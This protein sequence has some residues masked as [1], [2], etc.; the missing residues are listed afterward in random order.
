MIKCWN[1]ICKG[2]LMILS[3]TKDIAKLL[4]I[5]TKNMIS[6]S[7]QFTEPTPLLDDWVMGLEFADEG[8][9]AVYLI[10]AHSGLLL[11]E[12]AAKAEL[13][14]FLALFAQQLHDV[15]KGLKLNPAKYMKYF[16]RLFDQIILV[17]NDNRSISASIGQI[18]T[19]IEIME[20]KAY[21]VN[22]PLDTLEVINHYNNLIQR[23]HEW[24]SP[25]EV[26]RELLIK[27]HN[28]DVLI[29]PMEAA[30]ETFH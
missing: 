15:I 19:H 8:C 2:D 25:F 16:N 5:D 23:K 30:N 17:K 1:Y 3:I 18:K 28:D 29:K 20:D 12:I 13:E 22:L 21:W 27:H 24:L 26:F 4:K 9:Y 7:R 6:H 10:H 11:Y 14:L